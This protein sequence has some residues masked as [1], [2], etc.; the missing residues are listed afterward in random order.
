MPAVTPS[1]QSADNIQLESFALRKSDA[2][3]AASTASL[4]AVTAGDASETAADTAAGSAPDPVSAAITAAM[5]TWP[6]ELAALQSMDAAISEEI[7][8]TG[9]TCVSTLEA[10]DQK[11]AATI[12]AA[13]PGSAFYTV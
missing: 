6:T 13:I 11:S 7:T 8:A 10:E 3:T 1:G 9:A 12:K 2:N 5:S 4:S